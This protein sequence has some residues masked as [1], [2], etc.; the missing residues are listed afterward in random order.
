MC[1]ESYWYEARKRVEAEEKAKLDAEKKLKCAPP[2]KEL[3]KDFADTEIVI[4]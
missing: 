1:Y 3:E 4:V 2:A